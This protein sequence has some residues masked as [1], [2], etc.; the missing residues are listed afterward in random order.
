MEVVSATCLIFSSSRKSLIVKTRLAPPSK[1]QNHQHCS[2]T[3]KIVCTA[4][5]QQ[6]Q[7]KADKLRVESRRWLECDHRIENANWRTSWQM[8]E[9]PQ[10]FLKMRSTKIKRCFSRLIARD[11][12]IKPVLLRRDEGTISRTRHRQS[13][14]LTLLWKGTMKVP[15]CLKTSQW[16]VLLS[17][18]K[19]CNKWPLIVIL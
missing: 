10:T 3:G 12:K 5:P 2:T 7:P 13:I 9:V 17:Q 11:C 1:M 18:I 4:L 6:D 8:R 15:S 16:T 19:Q 14:W